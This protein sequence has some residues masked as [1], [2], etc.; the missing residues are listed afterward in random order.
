MVLSGEVMEP[1]GGAALLKEV[2]QWG[3]GLGLYSL[4]LLPV[5]CF[6]YVEK[7]MTSQLPV[8]VTSLL[9]TIMDSVPLG[10]AKPK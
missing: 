5:V 1:F 9:A 6:Q 10:A 2:H 3:A 7:N 8:P 4:T